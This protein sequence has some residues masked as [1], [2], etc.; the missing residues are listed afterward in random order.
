MRLMHSESMPHGFSSDAL[1]LQR[2]ISDSAAGLQLGLLPGRLRPLRAGRPV[3]MED[4]GEGRVVWLE[5]EGML[6]EK[7]HP[8][9]DSVPALMK[10]QWAQQKTRMR[11]VVIRRLLAGRFT[12]CFSVELYNNSRQLPKV[13]LQ[14]DGLPQKK[15]WHFRRPRQILQSPQ[16]FERNT[17]DKDGDGELKPRSAH[18]TIAGPQLWLA[19]AKH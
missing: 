1:Q 5:R 12:E 11:A 13:G 9:M 16:W 8:E 10:P 3:F 18:K 17:S 14:T 15:E 6:R 19:R 4:H 2:G 7:V